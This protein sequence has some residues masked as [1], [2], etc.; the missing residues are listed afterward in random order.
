MIFFGPLLSHTRLIVLLI[1]I[2]KRV[3]SLFS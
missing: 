1:I 3:V 2:K